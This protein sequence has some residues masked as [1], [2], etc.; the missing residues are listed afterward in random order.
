M[1]ETK[2]VWGAKANQVAAN[3]AFPKNLAVIEGIQIGTD[4]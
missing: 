1:R 4:A 2:G 3:K